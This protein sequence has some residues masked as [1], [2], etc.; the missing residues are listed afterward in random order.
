MNIVK[1]SIGYMNMEDIAGIIHDIDEDED[2]YSLC[3]SNTVLRISK[4]DYLCIEAWY[5][6]E[7]KIKQEKLI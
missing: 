5:M 6:K 7:S 1:L 2:S 4:T 3:I